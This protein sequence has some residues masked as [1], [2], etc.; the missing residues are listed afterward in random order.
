MTGAKI[1]VTGE[2]RIGRWTV[3]LEVLID[4]ARCCAR[5]KPH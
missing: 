1:R 5:R 2:R 3:V 4:V